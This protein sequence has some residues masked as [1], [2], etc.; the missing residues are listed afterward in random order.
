MKEYLFSFLKYIKDIDKFV[1]NFWQEK[2][3]NIKKWYLDQKDKSDVII[4]ASPEFLL[5]PL[6]KKLNI[7]VIASR[8]DKKTGKFLSKN[9]HDYEKINRYEEQFNNKIKNFYSDS[10]KADYPMFLYAKE[11]ILVKK[12]ELIKLD[13]KEIKKKIKK[14]EK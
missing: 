9:C 3:N 12:D 7:S 10:I 8:V 14:Y 5:K 13:K 11:A 6:E 1:E 4:S 2:I